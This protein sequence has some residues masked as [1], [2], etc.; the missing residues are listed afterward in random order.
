M[1]ILYP[2]DSRERI[3]FYLNRTWIR[4]HCLLGVYFSTSYLEFFSFQVALVIQVNI[5]P[6][7]VDKLVRILIQADQHLYNLLLLNTLFDPIIYAVR[8]PELRLGYINLLTQRKGVEMRNSRKSGPSSFN[9]LS[10]S[11]FTDMLSSY[12]SPNRNSPQN[13]ALTEL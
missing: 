12:K 3:T 5:N 13:D 6:D 7:S 2:T 8:I 4:W 11:G 10:H 1:C 9:R